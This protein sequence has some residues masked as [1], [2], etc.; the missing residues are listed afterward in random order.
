MSG[1][2][3]KIATETASG[4]PTTMKVTG[5]DST[6]DVYAVYFKNVV[7]SADERLGVRVTKGT[8]IQSD[9]TYN[10]ARSG[11]PISGNFQDNEDVGDTKWLLGTAESTGDGAFGLFHLFNFNNSSEY[12]FITLETQMWASTPQLFGEAGGGVHKVA[13]ASDGI[14][15]FWES[16]ATFSS[17]QMTL[18]GFKK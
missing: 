15:F 3:I 18:Y 1:S 11:M 7:P 17:G 2:L 8:S 6:Y 16:G 9:S 12:S 5:I 13:S 14:S 10:N 4:N